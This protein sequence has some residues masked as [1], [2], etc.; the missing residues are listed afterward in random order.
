MKGQ[1]RLSECHGCRFGLSFFGYKV[2]TVLPDCLT[3]FG[4]F[5]TCR[6]ERDQ[7]G[8]TQPNVA[9]LTFVLDSQEP[10]RSTVPADS[11]EKAI[12]VTVSPWLSQGGLHFVGG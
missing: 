5:R 12:A 7:L 1:G 2:A 3:S 10:T 8:T 4:S 11:Q 9:A 6:G